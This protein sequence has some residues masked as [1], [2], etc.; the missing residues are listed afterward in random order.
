MAPGRMQSPP[1]HTA[2]LPARGT[3][4][5]APARGDAT[6]PLATAAASPDAVKLVVLGGPSEGLE[7][8]LASVLRAGADPSC[9]LHLRDRGVSRQHA[10][11]WLRDGRAWVRDLGSR[12]GTTLGGVRVTEAELRL[13]SVVQLGETPI[14]VYP[15]WYVREVDPSGEDHFG[16]LFGTSLAMREVFAILERVAPADA[17]VLV[18]GESGTGKELVA[19]SL[20]DASGRARKP[21]VV[22]D[23]TTVTKELAES[24][25]FGHVR[26][27]FS[28]AVSDRDGAFRQADAGTIFLDEIGELPLDVQPKLLRALESGEIRR[29]GDSQYR[30]VDVRV[31]AA[32]HRDL[33]AEARRGRFRSD[34]F[35]RLSVVR[36][37]L[38]PLRA[39]PEDIAIITERLLAGKLAA[40]SRIEGRNLERL[41][42]YSWPGNVRE[43][44]N[45]LARALALAPRRDGLPAFEDL[46]VN[47]AADAAS[48]TTVGYC[49]PGV[50]AHLP[51]KEA[52]RRLM[53]QFDEEYVQALMRRNGHNVM[54]AAKAADVSRKHL[55][56]LLR[57]VE[58]GTEED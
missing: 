20:H 54:Q 13:G 38:P 45:V 23:C 2:D 26:G 10:E 17:T 21:Y 42:S 9:D 34:L 39:R 5:S 6:E 57:R 16:Q 30:K 25:L 4:V 15:R 12:N 11:F 46:A 18:E 35:Y 55:Y 56:E 53:A 1:G 44:R 50:D 33:H 29:V 8:A 7:R 41:G 52:K 32:T 19:R 36:V 14:A 48:P 43:L 24:E 3:L 47:L 28:G 58:S 27:A 49:F 37:T 31:V 51:Y 40:G 22:F